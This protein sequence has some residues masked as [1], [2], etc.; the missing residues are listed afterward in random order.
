MYLVLC[1]GVKKTAFTLRG[2]SMGRVSSGSE[3]FALSGM[4]PSQRTKRE[5]ASGVAVRTALPS[6]S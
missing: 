1:E 2:R 5:P 6:A 3:A 4:S